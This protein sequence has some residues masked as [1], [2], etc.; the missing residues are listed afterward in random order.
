[1]YD[2]VVVS[3]V[4]SKSIDYLSYGNLVLKRGNLVVVETDNGLQLAVVKKEGY[5]EKKENTR[6]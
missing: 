4:N 1:M 6:R 5:K 3:F 2:V